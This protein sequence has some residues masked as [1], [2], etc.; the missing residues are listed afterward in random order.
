MSKPKS[1]STPEIIHP[2]GVT[3][4][5]PDKEYFA[6]KALS[7]SFLKKFRVSP[8]RAQTDDFDGS[9]ATDLGSFIHASLLSPSELSNFACLP[10]TGEGSKK[11]REAWKLENPEGVLLSP[12][13]M[14]N[15]HSVIEKL[16]KHTDFIGVSNHPEVLK[17]VV[18]QCKHPK[19]GFPMKAKLDLFIPCTTI[20]D[21]K[22]FGSE[23]TKRV[24]YYRIIESGYDLQ[25]AHY[26]RMVQMI[27]N[28]TPDTMEL[29]FAETET[30]GHD[31][32]TVSID[33]GW[34]AMAEMKLDG[35]YEQYADCVESG[36]WPGVNYGKK[37]TLSL[38]EKF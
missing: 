1:K 18:L 4:G 25:L 34:L 36:V 14:D 11:A 27:Y 13:Q 2:A 9:A 24:L 5:M 38:G 29:Y 37:L 15:G 17:E 31:V 28:R 32:C 19:F 12:S 22:T 26:R 23:M 20:G 8:L 30:A 35:L 6:I 7:A 16:K 10:T 3:V 21:I 33:D